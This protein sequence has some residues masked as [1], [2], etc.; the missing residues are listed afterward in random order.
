M[1]P[2]DSVVYFSSGNQITAQ[3]IQ[4]DKD[5]FERIN[6]GQV[7]QNQEA[8]LSSK[9]LEGHIFAR[10]RKDGDRFL[11]IGAPGTKK[12]S[13]WMIDRKWTQ[14]EKIET[15]VLI[16]EQDEILWIPGFS[17]SE[18]A[19]VTKDDRKVIRLTYLKLST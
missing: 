10:T 12:V 6:D 2:F 11:P 14:K 16:D 13:D 19:K 18:S 5:L 1:L 17:P 4:L 8:F 15:P 7:D 9:K 3:N